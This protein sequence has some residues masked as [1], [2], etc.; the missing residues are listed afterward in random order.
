M[1]LSR[2]QRHFYIFQLGCRAG[3]GS[4]F[5]EPLFTGNEGMHARLLRSVH[6]SAGSKIQQS[7]AQIGNIE[8]FFSSASTSRS[9]VIFFRDWICVYQLGQCLRFEKLFDDFSNTIMLRSIL[10]QSIS[11]GT[12]I[13]FVQ[14]HAP[15]NYYI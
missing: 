3:G 15:G 6:R 11:T 8:R 5:D 4:K 2:K 14:G 7:Q 12:G 10:F 13:F 1:P 9:E